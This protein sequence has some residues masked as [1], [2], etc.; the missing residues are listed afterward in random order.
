MTFRRKLLTVFTLTVF[1][2]VAAVA[3]LVQVMTRTAFETTENQRT[4]A[5][6]TQ[7]QREFGRRS[8]DVARRVAAIAASEPVGRMAATFN[9]TV[10]DSAEYF[11]LARQMAE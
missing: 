2:S 11:D 8:D 3:W 5:L 6:V 1:L 9:G 4:A 7:F 10:S